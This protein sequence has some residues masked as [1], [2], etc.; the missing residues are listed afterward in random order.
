MLEQRVKAVNIA[1]LSVV[2]LSMPA[3]QL[4]MPETVAN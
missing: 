2:K 3:V 4:L 1:K